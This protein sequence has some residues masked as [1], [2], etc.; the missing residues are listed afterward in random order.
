MRCVQDYDQNALL[1][2]NPVAGRKTVQHH[3]TQ[4]IRILMNKG[5]LV[6]TMVSSCPGEVTEFA[7]RYGGNY[8]L[9]VCA[10]GD[11]TLHEA[12]NGLAKGEHQ[13]PLGYI[14]CGSTNDFATSH[15]LQTDRLK[16][17]CAIADG[18]SQ[19]YDI[20]RFNGQ[21]FTYV[22]AFG[23]F[24]WMAY[25][26]D[27]S[28]KN[29]IGYGAYLL[30]GARDLNRLKPLPM[31]LTVDNSTIYEGEYLY[32]SIS[33][34]SSVGG[35]IDFPNTMVDLCDGKFEV[36]LVKAPKSFLE[37]E[38]TIHCILVQDFSHPNLIL[39]QG[40]D[41]VIENLAYKEWCLDGES[42]G[43]FETAHIMPV[44]GFLCLRG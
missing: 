32:G 25:T 37:L 5:Y 15:G 6:T 10:G 26:T 40:S 36:F 35:I 24:T 43:V 14:P 42:S 30:D 9:L 39:C 21:Y 19:I 29:R 4:I 28:I 23:A 11:G 7:K 34:S 31:R 2:I 38:Q 8:D 1:L 41:I 3:L 18:R 16:S 20:G 17:A 44:P 22:A 33:N 27:Q 12:V 13:T